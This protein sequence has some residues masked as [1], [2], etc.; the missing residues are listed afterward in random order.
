MLETILNC[1]YIPSVENITKSLSYE[2]ANTAKK[3]V[4][5]CNAM[6]LMLNAVTCGYIWAT[7]MNSCISDGYK[8]LKTF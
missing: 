3:N 2:K 8:M 7:V 6:C 4:C 1:L 5:T